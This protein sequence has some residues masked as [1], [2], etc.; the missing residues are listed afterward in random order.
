MHGALGI[1]SLLIDREG[2]RLKAL[3]KEGFHLGARA[4]C[5]PT[6]SNAP[7]KGPYWKQNTNLITKE[8]PKV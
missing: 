4:K 5:G 8:V 2:L 6:S 3:P 7:H 1:I